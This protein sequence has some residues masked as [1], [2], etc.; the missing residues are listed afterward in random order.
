MAK[1][2][3]QKTNDETVD[4]VQRLTAEHMKSVRFIINETRKMEDSKEQLKNDVKAL[5]DKLGMKA[6]KVN[7]IIGLIRK[8]EEEGGIVQEQSTILEL[9]RTAVEDGVQED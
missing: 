7:K 1:A 3:E 9:V 2:N 5:A 8:E 4:Q 6:A